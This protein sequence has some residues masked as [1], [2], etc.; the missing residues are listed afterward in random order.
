MAP[1]KP[2]GKA[3]DKRLSKSMQGLRYG[4][5]TGDPSAKLRVNKNVA[6]DR[7]TTGEPNA[8][9][10]V[11]KS[12][13][14]DRMTTGEPNARMPIGGFRPDPKNKSIFGRKPPVKKPEIEDPPL[15]PSDDTD[16]PT[17]PPPASP[18]PAT[19]G[20]VPTQWPEIV[21]YFFP[22]GGTGYKDGGLVR[23]GGAAT[24]GRGRGRIV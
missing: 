22:N 7:M 6:G 16:T 21:D 15:P 19:S 20:P 13:A 2:D 23:G 5:I 1:K 12:V 8:R 4:N 3:F 9:L 18:P 11:N 17:S 24:K 10:S 14:G